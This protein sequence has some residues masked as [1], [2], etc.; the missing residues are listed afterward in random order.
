MILAVLDVLKLL[1]IDGEVFGNGWVETFSDRDIYGIAPV[2]GGL[3]V[4]SGRK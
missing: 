1:L 2:D 3:V 4:Q